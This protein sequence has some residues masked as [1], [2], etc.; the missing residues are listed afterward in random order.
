MEWRSYQYDFRRREPVIFGVALCVADEVN[1][2]FTDKPLPFAKYQ[3]TYLILAC[4]FFVVFFMVWFINLLEARYEEYAEIFDKRN[5]E[6]RDFTLEF[7][8]LPCDHQ[9]GGKELMF[10]ANLWNFIEKHVK[11]AIMLTAGEAKDSKNKK[12]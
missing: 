2:P 11:E 9:Y 4:D 12:Q 5:V 7:T 1:I 8:D 3:C 6:M 10:Q